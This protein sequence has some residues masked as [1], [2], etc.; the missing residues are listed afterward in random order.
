[1]YKFI[2]VLVIF[3]SAC[4]DDNQDEPAAVNKPV[5][6]QTPD[7]I[8]IEKKVKAA[9]EDEARESYARAKENIRVLK[10]SIARADSGLQQKAAVINQYNTTVGAVLGDLTSYSAVKKRIEEGGDAYIEFVYKKAVAE[11]A[12]RKAAAAAATGNA[13]STGK[14]NQ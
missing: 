10:E 1:M 14:E 11:I 13:D 2:A 9:V 8:S 7:S 5:E 6:K 3:L 4:S 12:M